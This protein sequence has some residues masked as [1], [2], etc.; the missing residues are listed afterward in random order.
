MVQ[1]PFACDDVLA[2]ISARFKLASANLLCQKTV[3][4]FELR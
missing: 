2:G 1:F 3:D 4:A